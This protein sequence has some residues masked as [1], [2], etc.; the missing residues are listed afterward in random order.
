[1]L[2]V[3]ETSTSGDTPGV[4]LGV[5]LLRRSGTSSRTA[6]RSRHNEPL[7]DQ[8]PSTLKVEPREERG[9]ED[10]VATGRCLWR[11]VWAP[12]PSGVQTSMT[13]AWVPLALAL[14][15]RWGPLV[16]SK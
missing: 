10:T 13:A 7:P 11:K 6:G 3:A 2:A 16:G 15:T 12:S 14:G 1:M 5:V 8:L 9:T 4:Q